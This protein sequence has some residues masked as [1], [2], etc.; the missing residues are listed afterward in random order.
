MKMIPRLSICLAAALSTLTGPLAAQ[1]NEP[2]RF[3]ADAR[4]LPQEAQEFS[5]EGPQIHMVNRRS[6]D[7]TVEDLN[8]DG[9]A[10]I[11][12]T[13]NEKSILEGFYRKKSPAGQDDQFDTQTI[14][15]D[16]IIRSVVAMDVNGDGRND[17]LMAGSPPRLVVMYQEER[18]GDLHEGSV[19]EAA[20]EQDVDPS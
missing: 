1:T 19:A 18:L 14:T 10:D 15:L 17:L 11:L 7:L 16:R 9:L 6:K 2:A 13:T 5:L 12:V 8:G 4:L 3:L 20:A